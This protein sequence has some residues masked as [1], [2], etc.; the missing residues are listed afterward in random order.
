M[1][2]TKGLTPLDASMGLAGGLGFDNTTGDVHEST[3]A[4]LKQV[5][6]GET[7]V[8]VKRSR[9]VNLVLLTVCCRRP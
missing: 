1:K 4:L 6:R 5:D 7:A 2:D 3:A 9:A 8:A